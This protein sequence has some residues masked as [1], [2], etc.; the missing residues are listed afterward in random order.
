[1]WNVTQ[2]SINSDFF[3]GQQRALIRDIFE[4]IIQPDWHGRIDQ[5]LKD[6]AG[7]FGKRQSIA[8]FGQPGGDKFEFVMTG[9]H[10]TLRCDGNS[11]E[12]VAFG[13]PIFYGHAAQGF[14]EKADHPGNV[15]WPQ[16]L[17][18]NKVF[19]M[20]DGQQR[21][22]ALVGRSPQESAVGFRGPD[23][24]RPGI[25]VSELSA[26]QK[27]QVQQVLQKLI[28]PYRQDDRDEVLQCLKTHG[29][30][31]ACSLA[32]YREPDI[33][34]DGV[35]DNWRLEGPAFVWYFRGA[36]HVH[37]WVNVAENADMKLNA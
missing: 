33:G 13:G 35:W 32:F 19:E 14:H 1:N 31:D 5:Q 3:S 6:D 29:G 21:T 12:H 24:Q 25:P 22:L 23:G 8:I 11:A 9:R 15:F 2:P 34:G 28:E 20:L 16:A 18:A 4:G 36:P 7:G 17:A 10:M 26:D 30:L 27:Q 37:V